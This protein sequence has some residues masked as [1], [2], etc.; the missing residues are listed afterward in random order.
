[1]VSL[2]AVEISCSSLDGKCFLSLCVVALG[3]VVH[4]LG[5]DWLLKCLIK[6]GLISLRWY[7]YDE[8]KKKLQEE[9]PWEL[10]PDASADLN[11]M[12]GTYSLFLHDALA[13]APRCR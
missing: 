7:V 3:R 12:A 2:C 1:M 5:R 11:W 13:I 4:D 9:K 10:M 8:I 6:S